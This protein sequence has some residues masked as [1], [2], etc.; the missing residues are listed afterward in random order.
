MVVALQD[1]VFEIDGDLVEQLDKLAAEQG[2]SRCALV[3]RIVT[4]AIDAAE[5]EA[6]DREL[7]EAYRQIPQDPDLV[8]SASRVAAVTTPEW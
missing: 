6:S 2:M 3:R 8:A 4:T 1:V 7:Q 5:T